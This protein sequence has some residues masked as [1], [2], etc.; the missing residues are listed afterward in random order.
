MHKKQVE[1]SHKLWFEAEQDKN[2]TK[3]VPLRV[4]GFQQSSDIEKSRG[5]L[6]DHTDEGKLH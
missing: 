1:S 5:L 6:S 4:K 2:I 3:T